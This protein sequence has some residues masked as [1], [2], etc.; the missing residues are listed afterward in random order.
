MILTKPF[1]P[2][3]LWRG[4]RA[5]YDFRKPKTNPVFVTGNLRVDLATKDSNLS[6]RRYSNANENG[7]FVYS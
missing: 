1:E 2:V 6:G 4:I 7:H 3:K 5:L